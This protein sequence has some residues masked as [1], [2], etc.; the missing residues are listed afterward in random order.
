MKARE[1][2]IFAFSKVSWEYAS[3]L[4]IGIWNWYLDLF[5]VRKKDAKKAL[6]TILKA[7]RV[8]SKGAQFEA[9]I[10]HGG[11]E[12]LQE[13][14][15]LFRVLRE[16]IFSKD[17]I[18]KPKW[19]ESQCDALALIANVFKALC[20]IGCRE[21]EQ[22]D[23]F[24]IL[25]MMSGMNK[26]SS[27]LLIESPKNATSVDP[28][29]EV[30]ALKLK[31]RQ[32]FFRWILKCYTQEWSVKLVASDEENSKRIR[33]IK[34]TKEQCLKC[35]Q[36]L[37]GLGNVISDEDAV[38]KRR[39]R[40]GSNAVRENLKDN[41]ILTSVKKSLKRN[42]SEEA[43]SIDNDYDISVWNK[44]K[45]L[46]IITMQESETGRMIGLANILNLNFEMLLPLFLEQAFNGSQKNSRTYFHVIVIVFRRTAKRRRGDTWLKTNPRRYIEIMKS[47]RGLGFLR[48]VKK[49]IG[50]LIFLALFMMRERSNEDIIMDSF[51]LLLAIAELVNNEFA[52]LVANKKYAMESRMSVWTKQAAVSLSELFSKLDPFISVDVVTYALRKKEHWDWIAVFIKPWFEVIKISSKSDIYESTEEAAGEDK[53]GEHFW[54]AD[55]LTEAKIGHGTDNKKLPSSENPLSEHIILAI[56]NKLYWLTKV[57]LSKFWCAKILDLWTLL[58]FSNFPASTHTVLEYILQQPLKEEYDSQVNLECSKNIVVTLYYAKGVSESSGNEGVVDELPSFSGKITRKRVRE[59]IVL[60]MMRMIWRVLQPA[61]D[62]DASK[63]QARLRTNRLLSMLE[64]AYFEEV[65]PAESENVT[66]N[67]NRQT[68]GYTQEYEDEIRQLEEKESRGKRIVNQKYDRKPWEFRHRDCQSFNEGICL[69]S[70]SLEVDFLSLARK[71]TAMLLDIF[72]LDHSPFLAYFPDILMFCFTFYDRNDFPSTS[73]YIFQLMVRM[74]QV[75]GDTK[76]LNKL[77]TDEE[78]KFKK[79]LMAENLELIWHCKDGSSQQQHMKQEYISAD[80]RTVSIY[81]STFILQY[82]RQLEE[83]NSMNRIG[84]QSL[85]WAILSTNQCVT[86]KVYTIY[87]SL[88]TPLNG[89]TVKVILFALLNSLEHFESSVW[90]I[91]KSQPMTESKWDTFRILETLLAITQKLSDTGE[92]PDYP[93]IF[94]TACALIRCDLSYHSQIELY[95]RALKLL[96]FIRSYK[97]LIPPSRATCQITARGVSHRFSKSDVLFLDRATCKS[98]DMLPHYLDL[99][100]DFKPNNTDQAAVAEKLPDDFFIYEDEG[101]VGLQPQLLQG[102]CRLET[103]TMSLGLVNTLTRCSLDSIV[104]KGATRHLTTILIFLPVIYT[105]VSK[106]ST[107]RQTGAICSI[108]ANL[109][110]VVEP[111]DEG[112]S[113]EFMK[114]ADAINSHHQD[115]TDYMDEFINNICDALNTHFFPQYASQANSFF[116]EL[117]SCDRDDEEFIF[118]RVCV[119]NCVTYFL[120]KQSLLVRNFDT[121]LKWA[122]GYVAKPGRS[123][124]QKAAAQLIPLAIHCLRLNPQDKNFE[125][126]NSPH[127]SEIS[128]SLLPKYSLKTVVCALRRI[129]RYG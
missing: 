62:N 33:Y 89:G 105:E 91:S 78:R 52:D 27:I 72:G 51:D 12:R 16:H 64:Q 57:G 35:L 41:S 80:G 83:H 67:R 40:I 42:L 126:P 29:P 3:A 18:A 54:Y 8:I 63:G 19:S 127:K 82:C 10:V 96:N 99:E 24:W 114:F 38:T 122:H 28:T 118:W 21:E 11:P 112:M 50:K 44:S 128:H 69:T 109:S 30:K 22:R 25:P 5:K 20:K 23:L 6:P 86:G 115:A 26:R 116:F 87:Q 74:L 49:A 97:W 102:L 9:A 61:A 65:H 90:N 106:T 121:C 60:F 92:L 13:L 85:R 71:T 70:K 98:I 100:D 73:T 47:Q 107:V 94:W 66:V 32:E 84:F 17:K 88:L 119:L 120:E 113:K 45:I 46:D 123:A 104:E 111:L 1:L 101:F 55:K 76:V 7:I 75:L 95:K 103:A 129:I 14:I 59:F 79:A 34:I 2:L 31:D 68:L 15:S 93:E 48:S 108:L 110:D 125:D 37:V 117:L 43:Q 36:Y 39:D 53:S 56:L 4:I 77:S 124:I 58:A 81:A